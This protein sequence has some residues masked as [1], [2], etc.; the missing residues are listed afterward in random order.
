MVVSTAPVVTVGEGHSVPIKDGATLGA[1]INWGEGGI[2]DDSAVGTSDGEH[3]EIAEG[4]CVGSKDGIE[5]GSQVG[6][7]DVI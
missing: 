7:A 2:G 3:D 5:V 1:T 4:S 6:G